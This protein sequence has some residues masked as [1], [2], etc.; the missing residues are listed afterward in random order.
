MTR[1][2]DDT[3]VRIAVYTCITGGYDTLTVPEVIDPRIDYFC[4]VDDSITPVAPWQARAIDLPHLDA[5]DQNRFIKMHP[6][7][8]FPDY[9]LTL[10]ID[11][12]IQMCGD[13]YDLVCQAA[14]A[15]A[16]MHAYAHPFR[17]CVYAEAAACAHYSHAWI[18]TIARQMRQY[19]AAGYPLDN[20]LFEA[21]VLI[22]RHT[23][24]LSALMEGWWH[25]YQR[26]SKR[27]QLSLPVIAWRLH[28]PIATLGPSDARFAQRY[29]RLLSRPK[30]VQLHLIIKKH[31]NRTLAALLGY[32]RLFG[33]RGISVRM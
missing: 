21:N 4:F 19:S 9:D 33:V 31:V 3:T 17:H 12:N 28:I 32:D 30:R 20:G 27:D 11:G 6:Q 26:G 24:A 2:Y 7:H 10:Y 18:W 25:E 15:P 29:F 5:K 14:S 16:D 22:R 13:I 8:Y 1:Q 23:P